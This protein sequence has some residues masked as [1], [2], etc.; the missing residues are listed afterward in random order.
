MFL[1]ER[2]L[3][4]HIRLVR[5]KLT[6]L[7]VALL[8]EV[9]PTFKESQVSWESSEEEEEPS[10]G[11]F[12]IERL[13]GSKSGRID[14]MLQDKT[15]EHPY[16]QAIGAHTNYWRDYDT[17]LFILK[18]LYQDTPEDSNLSAVSSM[19]KSKHESTSVGWYEP[20]D[21]VE[22][23]LPLTFSDKVLVRS[24][25]NKAKKV[26]QKHAAPNF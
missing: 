4:F 21:T 8:S 20:R 22:E 3:T 2:R 10:Y 12:M 14:H 18:H 24:F 17:A 5:L 19:D 23:D 9:Q 13:T 11:S 26:L 6:V 16:L 15:F 7:T 1:D 25:S